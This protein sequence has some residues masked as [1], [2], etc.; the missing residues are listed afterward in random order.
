MPSQ[1]STLGVAPK[2]QRGRDRVAAILEAATQ[3]F[4]DHGAAVT[5]TEIAARSGTAI[6]SLYRFFPTRDAVVA[7]LLERYTEDLRRAL[8]ELEA[9][10]ATLAPDALADALLG[11]A[12][13]RKAERTAALVLVEITG[14]EALRARLREQMRQGV[15][16]ILRQAG[17][18]PAAQAPAAAEAVVL[19]I[20]AAGSLAL[21]PDSRDALDEL[22]QL[23]R[24][25][26]EQRNRSH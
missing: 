18:V 21:Q 13:D 26:L 16:D 7:T 20:K 25:Y 17:T 3:L 1:K 2:R 8:S 23:L 11:L 6:G 9:R 15:G 24:H 22:R 12:L 10:A 19:L 14:D 4:I 5:M